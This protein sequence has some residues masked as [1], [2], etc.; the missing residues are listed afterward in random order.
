[1]N[2]PYLIYLINLKKY[3]FTFV[4]AVKSYYNLEIFVWLSSGSS[5]LLINLA[6]V[7]DSESV[8]LY[9]LIL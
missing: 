8:Y 5:G 7:S 3:V 6:S 4:W 9:V 1:M 2:L